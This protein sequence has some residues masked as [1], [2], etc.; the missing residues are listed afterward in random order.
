MKN[1][2]YEIFVCIVVISILLY[3][4]GNC[5]INNYCGLT[6]I[7][8]LVENGS[9]EYMFTIIFCVLFIVISIVYLFFI[10]K[11]RRL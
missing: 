6:K 7:S 5:L 2:Y 8:R 11:R 1:V 9:S 10:I 3:R 4:G